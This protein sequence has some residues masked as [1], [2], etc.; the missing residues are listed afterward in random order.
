MQGQTQETPRTMAAL[1]VV[2]V[3][4]QKPAANVPKYPIPD[5]ESPLDPH[6]HTEIPSYL[7]IYDIFIYIYIYIY[8]Y[9]FSVYLSI[10]L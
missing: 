1:L 10:H 4:W 6:I 9:I 7:Y 5:V 3:D 2:I 8:I